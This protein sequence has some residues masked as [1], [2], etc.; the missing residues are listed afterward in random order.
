M[1]A[2]ATIEALYRSE[3]G[4]ILPTLIRLVGDFALAEDALQEAFHAALEH[5]PRL[6][7]PPNPRAWLI[8]AAKH[9]AID[10]V[11]RAARF[12]KKAALV[13]PAL[14]GLSELLDHGP[15]IADDQLRLVY[16]CCHPAL[17]PE[18][19]VALTLRTLCGLTTDEVARAFLVPTATMAQRI[20]RAQ[21]KIRDAGIPY[22]VPEADQLAARTDA[23]LATIYLTFNEGYSATGG[24]RLLRVDLCEEAIRL[25][26]LVVGLLDAPGRGEALG[27]LALLVLHHARRE[28]RVSADGGL[29]LLDHQDRSRWRRDEAAE[30]LALLERALREGARGPYTTQ[31][32]I[33]ALHHRAPTAGETDW[34]QI[35]GLYDRLLTLD[36]SPVVA[37]N[38]AAALA[39]AEGAERGLAQIDDLARG[40]ALRDYHLLHA[41]R[42]DLLRRLGRFSEAAD[43]YREA[44][45]LTRNASE[46]AFLE[47]RLRGLAA[48]P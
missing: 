46:R 20:V 6:G 37:L 1:S 42:A 2:P 16:T 45:A 27:L 19:Q 34:P 30:G 22:A 15:A 31:A 5:W 33:A 17:S 4:R 11:R 47:A 41:A 29:V 28:A 18:A 24:P 7:T 25:G 48:G 8:Q 39:M 13:E 35:V 40:E 12:E 26:R 36:P 10:R 43:A 9:R 21:R 44:L 14:D 32:A 38:R 23:V 3:A